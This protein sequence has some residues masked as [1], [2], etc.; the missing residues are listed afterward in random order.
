MKILHTSDWHLG[1]TLEGHSRLEEQSA[2]IDEL[3]GI[4]S[5]E[6]I[7]LLLIAGDIFDTYN[8]PAEA[9]RLFCDALER[10]SAAGAAVAAAAGNH[11][12]PDRLC[13]VAPLTERYGISLIGYP[14]ETLPVS[15]AS[16][17]G[18]QRLDSGPGWFR[19]HLPRCGE[20]AVIAAMAYPSESRLN[21]LLSTSL[22]DADLQ[23]AYSGK[24]G[25]A[26]RAA[27]DNFGQDTV[28]IILGHFFLAGGLE[29]DSERPIQLG[30]AHAVN[31]DALPEADYI[32]LGH[33]HRPQRLAGGLTGF[34]SGSPLAYSF[35]EAGQQ[36][37]VI[38]VD[39]APGRQPGISRI[40]LHSGKP[41]KRWQ[42]DNPDTAMAWCAEPDNAGCW[43]DLEIT[44]S[45]PLSSEYLA[46]LRRLHS[47][48]IS[49]RPRLIQA[50]RENAVADR[51]ELSIREQFR[52]FAASTEGVEPPDELIDMFMEML[53]NRSDSIDTEVPE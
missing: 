40:G 14:A 51:R 18:P 46:D 41:L 21:L 48:I 38:L 28:N 33:L 37:E 49:V 5:A 36:K 13:A 9:E 44:T 47:G 34:Y 26:L 8:P 53:E 39:A 19:L 31:A 10:L 22:D 25:T 16:A 17:S 45:Q 7:D 24:I 12:S 30:G 50:D 23:A 42:A 32:A 4:V 2:F 6:K 20:T 15:G 43:V 3:C 52:L 35:S 1:R 11:D 27:A 29:S